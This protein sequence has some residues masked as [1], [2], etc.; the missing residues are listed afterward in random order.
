MLDKTDP[1]YVWTCPNS[2][3]NVQYRGVCPN[4]VCPGNLSHIPNR[5]SGCF[6]NFLDNKPETDKY[7]IAYAFAT[8]HKAV[9]DKINFGK[10]RIRRLMLFSKIVSKLE[11]SANPHRCSVCEVKRLTSGD[12]INTKQC[13]RRASTLKKILHRYPFNLS[14]FEIEARDIYSLVEYEKRLAA[15]VRKAKDITLADVLELKPKLYARLFSLK[16]EI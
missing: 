9:E 6:Y 3:N 11:T 1:D 12:C 2:P 14:H 8:S 13:K 4:I 15:Y 16:T 10:N 5:P 7:E